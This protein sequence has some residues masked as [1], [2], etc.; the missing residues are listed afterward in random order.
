L[1]P[2][3]A[4]LHSAL[5]RNLEVKGRQAEALA[6]HRHALALD[7]GNANNQTELRN[8]LARLGRGNEARIAWQATLEARP[9]LHAD[10]YGYPE[11]CVFLGQEEEYRRARRTLLASFGTSTD[12]NIAERTARA[13]LLLPAT[14]DEL[15]QAGALA[16]RAVAAKSSKN[17]WV[18]PFFRFTQGLVEYRQGTFDRAISTMRGDA[19]PLLVPMSRLVLAMA[20]HRSGQFTEARK[21]LAAA[22]LAQDWRASQVN[23]QDDWMFHVLRRE[24]EQM[25]LPGLP[26]FL[27]GKYQPQ[28]N[29]ERLALLGICQ[30]TNRTRALARLYTDAFAAAPEMAE[31][32]KA[33]HR[34]NAARAAALAGSGY[35][36][37]AGNLGPEERRLWRKQARAWLE[38]DVAVWT[39]MLNSGGA[40]D[41]SLI[42]SKLNGWLANP[43]LASLRDPGALKMLAAEERD[44]WLALWKEVEAL[45]GRATNA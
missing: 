25:I 42:W 21:T 20:L 22:V 41:R 35:G 45:L 7:P 38:L 34:Y 17:R 37:D 23:N 16:D 15:R 28:D 14:E 18:Y 43:D 19:I 2:T 10:W 1:N 40:V 26:A 9:D 29:D 32:V 5:G 3:A 39:R 4:S 8:V 6:E 12:P 11:F 33:G 36:E 13:C 27:E 24:A 31:N 44:E 30:F